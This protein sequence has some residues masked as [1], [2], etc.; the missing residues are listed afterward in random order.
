MQSHKEVVI[1]KMG[2]ICQHGLPLHTKHL[3]YVE[4]TNNKHQLLYTIK[5]ID[6]GNILREYN[7]S[8]F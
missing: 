6:R 4:N 7:K 8:A 5:R 2:K 1:K 3:V